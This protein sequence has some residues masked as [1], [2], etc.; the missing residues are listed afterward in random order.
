MLNEYGGSR[1]RHR[2]DG[3]VLGDPESVIPEV[4][5]FDCE[6]G[7]L[8]EGPCRGRAGRDGREV[9]YG[10]GDHVRIYLKAARSSRLHRVG[11]SLTS[12]INRANP[13]E[14]GRR[15][16]LAAEVVIAAAVFLA[17]CLIVLLRSPQLLEPDD[18]AYRASIIALSEGHLLLTNA[19]YF[20]LKA[21]LSAHGGPGIEQWV[22]LRSGKWISQKNPGYPF[23][24]VIFQWFH[25]LRA[26]PLFYGAFGCVG[27]FYGARAWL[28]RWGGVYAVALYCFSGAALFFAWRAT[29]STFTDASLI[30]GAAGLLLGVLLTR[31]DPP[32]RRFILGALAFLALDGAV[33]IR[34]TDVVVIV[35]ALAV[36]L[37]LA[38]TCRVTWLTILGWCGIV[39][40]FGA[41]DL[42]INKVLYGGV[43]TT[44]YRPGI[45]SFRASAIAPNFERMP[46]RL[47]E[48]VPMTVLA[49]IGLNW[50]ATRF[51]S[52]HGF[53]SSFEGTA[54]R[55]ALVALAL[56]AGWLAVWGLYTTYTWT[57]GQTLGPGNPIHVVRFYVPVLGLI[58]LLGAWLLMRLP[59]WVAASLIAL[60]IA[61]ALWSY[62][63]PANDIIVGRQPQP[64][65][66]LSPSQSVT[67]WPVVS[68]SRG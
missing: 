17:M 25:A 24:A 8:T 56:G 22:H 36:V 34:Y 9:E 61:L 54:R 67:V 6:H 48:S 32:A 66:R 68:R 55:D 65:T 39:A 4:F 27:L 41:F 28:G 21:Q 2:G 26:A 23:F 3:V 42:V 40:A 14:T 35:V 13:G 18:Y 64:V 30:S 63:T 53:G 62:V 5:R 19:Q 1:T 37:G 15:L 52:R 10:E 57:V 12:S 20:A 31:S 43:F 38:R 29:M 49:L 58:A 51:F 47:V 50:I 11:H 46:S 59:K 7:R 44:G 16:S 45:V 60:V 33:F